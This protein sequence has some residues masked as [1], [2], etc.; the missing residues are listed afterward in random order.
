VWVRYHWLRVPW[1]LASL[2]VSYALIAA[3]MHF[4][5]DLI[6]GCLLGGTIGYLFLVAAGHPQKIKGGAE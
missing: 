3:E 4:L 5:S 6:G 2:G 1:I